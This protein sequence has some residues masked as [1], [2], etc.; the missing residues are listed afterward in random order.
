MLPLPTAPT[1][2]LS[3]AALLDRL[4]SLGVTSLMVEGGAGI[5][6]SFLAKGLVEHLVLTIAPCLV[7][8]VHAVRAGALPAAPGRPHLEG[9]DYAVLGQDTIVRADLRWSS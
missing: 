8:G 7:G 9:V 3:L 4:G 6:S 2:G 5:I 1:G